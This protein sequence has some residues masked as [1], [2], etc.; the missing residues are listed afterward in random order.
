[1]LLQIGYIICLAIATNKANVIY[2][3]LI[4]YKQVTCNLL[5]AELYKMTY[6]FDSEAVIKAI[7]EK[8]LG[9]ATLLIL[10]T[11]SKFFYDCLIKWGITKDKQLIVEVISLYQ[12]YEQQ[13]ITEVKWIN[14]YHNPADFI[15]KAKLLWVLKTLINTNC[16]NICITEWVE[17]ANIKQANTG[18]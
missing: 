10:H 2:W 17:R 5:I 1:M 16:I 18:T 11:D 13:K 12:S 6:K 14:E 15:T 7:L 4:K 8:I 3:F 9:S